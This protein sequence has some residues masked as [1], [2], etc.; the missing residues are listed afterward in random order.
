MTVMT[1]PVVS[2]IIATRNR[3]ALLAQTLDALAGQR[4]PADR[5]EILVADN[6]ST[7][8]TAA[9][10]KAAA[11]RRE[12]PATRYLS[13][14]DPGKSH[15]V[16]AA[17]SQ[18]RGDLL[19]FID[20]DVVPAPTWVGCLASAFEPPGV[21]FV[22]G[23]ILP[24]WEMPPPPWVS[25]P[26]YGVLAIPDNGTMRRAI[27]GRDPSVMPIGANMAVRRAVVD[28]LGGLR[29]DLGKLA[30]TL[31]TGEDHE[32]FLRMLRAG[33]VGSYEPTAV[34][35]HWVP[36]ARLTREYFRDWLFQNGR[37]VA[38]L[39]R[40]YAAEVRRWLRI[41]RYLWSQ[42]AADAQGW[43]RG[44]LVADGRARFA[45][46]LRLVWLGGYAREAWFGSAAT[47]PGGSV[48][49]GHDR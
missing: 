28:R 38:R 32:F 31:R 9:V 12:A 14:D 16:N 1:V 47:A 5:L 34:V 17:L 35:H 44:S 18:A 46:W 45:S 2:V 49:Q 33:C 7:D 42:A 29:T 10:V 43:A 39:D 19:A 15:A 20:D 6:S 25:P 8:D 22:A 11:G 3:A 21:D 23:R 48:P 4:W 24:R 26:L 30:G 36:R 40:E 13:V 41:P 37:D 27:D